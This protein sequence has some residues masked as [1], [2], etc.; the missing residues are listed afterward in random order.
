VSGVSRHA[1]E[2]DQPVGGQGEEKRPGCQVCTC[3]QIISYNH[4][5][6]NWQ[7]DPLAHS[8]LFFLFIDIDLHLVEL[9]DDFS[10]VNWSELGV[11]SISK[12]ERE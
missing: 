9:K 12:R 11:G 7:F 8:G 2:H 10:G 4:D 6:E 3:T 1:G 5:P